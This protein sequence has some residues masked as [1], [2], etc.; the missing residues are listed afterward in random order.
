MKQ[1][2][3][4]PIS[5]TWGA[6]SGRH[7]QYIKSDAFSPINTAGGYKSFGEYIDMIYQ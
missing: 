6:M 2:N 7:L 4:Q 5:K 3:G 1:S